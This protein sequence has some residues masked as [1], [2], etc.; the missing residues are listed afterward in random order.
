MG[1]RIVPIEEKHVEGFHAC[2]DIVAK[3]KKFLA[4]QEAPP[5]ESTRA[6][7]K[8]VLATG[9]VQFVALYDDA[10]VGWCDILKLKL[11]SF[12]HTGS[13]GMGLLPEYRGKGI[14]KR[15]LATAIEAAFASGMERIELMVYASNESA[16]RLYRSLGFAEEGRM[17]RKGKIDGVYLDMIAMALFKA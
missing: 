2:L 15:L 9:E 6:F 4:M 14:G 13:V 7:V 3:E 8:N 5:L 11:A 17:I 16:I 10:V 1:I 12:S